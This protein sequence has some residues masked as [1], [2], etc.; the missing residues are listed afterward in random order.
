MILMKSNLNCLILFAVVALTVSPSRA[1]PDFQGDAFPFDTSGNVPGDPKNGIERLKQIYQLINIYRMRHEGRYPTMVELVSD[2]RKKPEAYNLTETDDFRAVLKPFFNPDSRFS[3]TGWVRE[4]PDTVIAVILRSKRPNGKAIGSAKAP[5][6]RDVLAWSETYLYRNFRN[7]SRTLMNP[8]GFFLVLWDDGEV[9]KVPY[10]EAYMASGEIMQYEYAFPGQ[11]GIPWDACENY[12]EAYAPG[13]DATAPR[14]KPVPGGYESPVRD[15]G[16]PESLVSISR[17]TAKPVDRDR[18]WKLLDIKQQR[19]LLDDIKKV[20]GE[21]EFPLKQLSLTFNQLQE[22]NLPAIL[23]LSQPDK[24]VT[25]AAAGNESSL[26]YE[27]GAPRIVSNQ[28]LQRRYTGQVLIP[29]DLPISNHDIQVEDAVRLVDVS[30]DAPVAME[31]VLINNKGNEPI[32]LS[33]EEPACHCNSVEL[34]PQVIKAGESASVQVSLGWRSSRRGGKF[35]GF[36]P[37][38]VN[39]RTSSPVQP[40]IKLGFL[41]SN[42]P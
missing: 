37:V 6:T 1:Q 4:S 38:F 16:G 35:A 39:I 19:F 7:N 13:P 31:T 29:A 2:S 9:Q 20:S 41:L 17:L 21:V 36:Q 3:N 22:R 11:A 40:L 24:L 5:N 34:T 8:V 32:T 26:I 33:V 27:A 30:H 23:H 25:L 18:L 28:S 42:R 10:D 12:D 15:N 14:G